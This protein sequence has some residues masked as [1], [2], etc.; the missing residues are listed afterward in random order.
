MDWFVLFLVAGA[1]IA[2]GRIIYQI[3]RTTTRREDDW[4]TRM[5]ERLRRSGIDPFSPVEVDFFVAM[6]S[7]E[8]A[9]ALAGRLASDGF[10]IDLRP[11]EGSSEHPWSIHVRKALVLTAPSIREISSRLRAGAEAVGGR[12]D[13][14]AP[15]P[16]APRGP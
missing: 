3:R 2:V 16:A 11:I 15:G 9:D 4:D 14:W 6:P 7:R 5:I 8:A 1:A 10:T 12:Y 13:G